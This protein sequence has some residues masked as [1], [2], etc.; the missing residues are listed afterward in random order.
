MTLTKLKSKISASMDVLTIDQKVGIALNTAV[1]EVVL[2]DMVKQSTDITVITNPAGYKQAQTARIALRDQR[3]L[4]EKIGKAARDEA[5]KFSKAVIAEERR[6]IAIIE[7]EEK[8]LQAVQDEF[9]AIKEAEK[10]AALTAEKL[11]VENHQH[12]IMSIRNSPLE[13]V[14]KTADE[15]RAQIK[16]LESIDISKLEEYT[17]MAEDALHCAFEKL[18]EMVKIAL[19]REDDARKSAEQAT[20]IEALKAQLAEA[21]AKPVIH[22]EKSTRM[23]VAESKLASFLNEY[24]DIKVFDTINAAIEVYFETAD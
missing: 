19:T 4:I 7:P 18:D 8:R 10:T 16:A 1:V 12:L 21:T 11:R 24:R 5:Q 20:E 23:Q 9:D 3:C 14:N 15:I 13:Y 2:T 22:E 6:L 17:D